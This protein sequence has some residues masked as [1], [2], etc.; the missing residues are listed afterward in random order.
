MGKDMKLKVCVMNVNNFFYFPQFEEEQ[1]KGEK[2]SFKS[3]FIIQP[4]ENMRKVC[5]KIEEALFELAY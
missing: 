5:Q 3:I 4:D 2:D 1:S